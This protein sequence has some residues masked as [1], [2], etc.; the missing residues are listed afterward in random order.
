MVDIG[1]FMNECVVI[2]ACYLYKVVFVYP[3]NFKCT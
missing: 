2:L 1:S 3:S